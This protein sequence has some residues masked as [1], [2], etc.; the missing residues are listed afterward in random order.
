MGFLTTVTL[1]NCLLLTASVTHAADV[2]PTQQLGGNSPWFQGPDVNDIPYEVPDGCYVDMAAFVS[3]HGSRY[4]DQGAYNGWV[5]LSAKVPISISHHY[6]TLANLN[7]SKLLSSPPQGTIASSHHGSL[8]F[9]TRLS[10]SQTS[11]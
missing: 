1:A 8:Y 4:P 9:A 2:D 6:H 3:R 11:L 5:A 10:R 7:R